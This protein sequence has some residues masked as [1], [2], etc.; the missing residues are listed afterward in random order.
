MALKD[1]WLGRKPKIEE[2]TKVGFVGHELN[3]NAPLKIALNRL[4]GRLGRVQ[5]LLDGKFARGHPRHE[6]F[7]LE[8]RRLILQIRFKQGVSN[9]TGVKETWLG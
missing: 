6:E 3:V 8:K 4:Q 1:W 7:R 9:L 2:P 5:Q